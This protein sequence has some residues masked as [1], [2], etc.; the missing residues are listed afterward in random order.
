MTEIDAINK[1][2]RFIGELPIPNDVAI[3]DLDE[4]HEA[5]TARIILKETIEDEQEDRWWFNKTSLTLIPTTSGYIT[6]PPN[7][8]SIYSNGKYALIGNDLFDIQGQTKIFTNSVTVTALI[9]LKF[10]DLPKVF[11]TYVVL[12]AS[13]SLHISLNGDE[14]TQAELNLSIQLQK[15]KLDRENTRQSKV[16]LITGGRLLDR[17]SNPSIQS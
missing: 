3:D 10:E 6:L 1:M 4:G 9:S 16:N 12:K 5:L 13:K 17:N 14:T 7:I 8:V 2:L 11:K 15:T